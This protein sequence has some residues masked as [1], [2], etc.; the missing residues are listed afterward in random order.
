MGLLYYVSYFSVLAAFGF[1]TLS[2]ASGL[3]YVSELIE[4]HSRLAKQI[5]Q[6]G[7]YTIILLHVLFYFT[8]SLPLLQT[9]FSITCHVVY[10][11]NFSYTWPLIS[12][13]SPTFLGSCALVIADHFI[14]FFYFSR[15]THEAR[16]AR[17]YRGNG[18]KAPGF[19]EIA[20]F[21]GICVWLAP[22][23]LFLSLSANDN[24]L[25]TSTAEPVSPS[26]A[27]NPA[28][29]APT[30]ISLFRSIFSS[31]FGKLPGVRSRQ[32]AN[33][34]IIA[35]RS[36][37]ITRGSL[38]AQY[39]HPPASPSLAPLAPPRSPG[40]PR[41]V[42]V[43][44]AGQSRSQAIV[45][46]LPSKEVDRTGLVKLTNRTV[47]G[48]LGLIS[49][50]N[51]IFLAVVT[52]ATEIGNTR[53]SAHE[54]ESVARIHEV[55]FYSLN[56]STWDDPL[57]SEPTTFGP[58]AVDSSFR[59]SYT[60]TSVFEHPCLPLTKIL[61][62]GTFY[63][64]MEPTW[65]LS[66]RL[67]VRLARDAASS[68]DIGTFDERFIW[69]EYIL[70]SLLDFRE[71]LDFHER[72][73]LDRCQFL[74]PAIQG[75]VGVFSLPLRA[76]PTDG[77]P[78]VATLALISRLGWKRAGTR[79][80]TRGVD[81]DGNCANFVETETVFSTDQ[82]CVS[83]V[84]IRGSV[85]LFWEQQGLQTFGQRIQITRPHASQPAFERHL[86][87]LMEEYGM[88]HAINLLGTKE[89]E[90]LLTNSYGQHLRMA[91][92]ALGDNLDITHFDF[93]NIVRLGGHE[94]VIK[95]LPKIESVEDHVDKFGFSMCDA[96]TD[97]IITD[98]KGVFRTNCLD[99]LDRTNFVQD[100]LSKTTL[101]QYL[102]LVRREW[103]TSVQLWS[104]HRELWAEN[105]DALSRIYAGTGALNTSFTRSGKRTLAG[106]LS[107]ATKSVSRAYINNFQDKGKQVAI[108]MFLGN[109]SDQRQVTIRDP[110]HDTVHEALERRWAEYSTTKKAT[111][112]VGTW[113][114]NGRITGESLLPWLFPRDGMDVRPDILVLGFQEIVPL[115]AQQIVQTDPEKRRLWEK[116][117][118]DNIERKPGRKSRYVLLR[119]EQLV[120]TALFVIVKEELASVIRNV[121]GT[122]RKTG[123]RGM[124]GNK[125]A[126]G[127]RLDYYDTNFCFVTAHLAAG[128]SNMEER[129]ADYRTIT[130]GLH[131]Q[132][133]KTI[134]S[135]DNVI[136]LADTNY[137]IDLDNPAVRAYAE[138]DDFDPLFAADQL[139]H[140]I[141]T[142]AAFVGYE[143]GPLLFRP[144]Y[145]YDVGTNNYDTSEKMRIPAWT[146]R[147]LY[148][149]PA[150]DLTVYSRT[151]LRGSDHKPVFGIFKADI[152]IVDTVKKAALSQLLLENIVSTEP[153]ENLDE[154]LAS[155]ALPD[156]V[157]ELPPPS[158]DE[159][160]WWDTPGKSLPLSVLEKPRSD[161]RTSR[162]RPWRS[163]SPTTSDE[164]L[165]TSA[166]ALQAPLTPVPV[167][168][169]RPPP[170]PPRSG[171]ESKD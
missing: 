131:F 20:S 78:T 40:R 113:N 32:D 60:T 43:F 154:K 158:T 152:R 8:D 17:A 170:P 153:G 129:N 116:K 10:L 163:L 30:R 35:P 120:G 77:A 44:R 61:S 11:Q 31:S 47:K 96:S 107:D 105:G 57:L 12:L 166:L 55:G 71:R 125:G 42:L 104:N 50:D 93:H 9:V 37:N 168:T 171:K 81:D 99:C 133:G 136:W 21:F 25:P 94:T 108:D 100:I 19:T 126:V 3:L 144:T 36:P 132:K 149:G 135:H 167:G 6:R 159:K 114:L 169:R 70:R 97:E 80:N 1:V 75:Y 143:E 85:P 16:Y 106:V 109:L 76:P 46:F 83:Y 65:D 23:F 138:A 124:S 72:E 147:I 13:S 130:D 88:I 7:I 52:S 29:T 95:N 89:N 18:L 66:S 103:T 27:T 122:S 161:S 110:I 86:V 28:T 84:Q 51:D 58:E 48:C 67:A 140:V 102:N 112:M 39:S 56:S 14:W 34:G 68:R 62:S 148:R 2:L 160:A 156:T 74:I 151:E 134:A 82:H 79:F 165:Y 121:E 59:E 54:P 98:Q 26:M 118:M 33:E 141:D 5:G 139:R 146:D 155:I 162:R 15:I 142:G 127:I 41:R 73:E 115:T 117:V 53:P 123:L 119:S 64:A 92:S 164:E 22:L 90:A 24:A 150:L 45:K 69:N 111:I 49:V 157:G 91:R 4:E 63:Y 137:R 87:Q 128:H 38:P 145:R 101:E